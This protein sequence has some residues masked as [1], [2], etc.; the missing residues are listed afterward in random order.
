MRLGNF[1]IGTWLANWRTALIIG[2]AKAKGAKIH[3]K[4]EPNLTMSIE[5]GNR[6]GDPEPQS[7]QKPCPSPAT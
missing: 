4:S 6:L 3:A 2:R 7:S 1:K 5:K